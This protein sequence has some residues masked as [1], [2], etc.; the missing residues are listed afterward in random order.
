MAS[1]PVRNKVALITGGA[2]GIGLAIAK[3]LLKNGVKGVAL[4]DVSEQNGS[5]AIKEIEEQFGK[6]KAVFILTDVRSLASFEGAFTK[7]VETF[8]AV[9]ILVNNA[10]ILD[11]SQWNNE[12][13]I[14]LKGTINGIL[15]GFEKYLQTHRSG[16]QAVILN[17]SSIA[18]VKAMGCIPVY[19]STKFA[20]HGLTVA[21]GT[22]PH[23]D[24]TM[25]KVVAICPGATQTNL[26]AGMPGKNLGPPYEQQRVNEVHTP[27]QSAEQCAQGA[28][29]VIELASTGSVWII[30]GGEN[31]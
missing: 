26:L 16:N 5:K 24:R 27:E 21:W 10:G 3:E 17:V 20:V 29:Q 9:D 31:P 28:V 23:Y 6:S 7:T 2:A 1:F 15:L 25:V 13:D 18:G 30:E 11:D 4:A 14:N 12:I 8:K 22:Q 19:S